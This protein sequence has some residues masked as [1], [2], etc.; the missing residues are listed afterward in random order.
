M[1]DSK[2]NPHKSPEFLKDW[3]I[4]DTLDFEGIT[5]DVT[6]WNDDGYTVTLNF[7]EPNETGEPPFSGFSLC[8]QIGGDDLQ[9]VYERVDILLASGMFDG[10]AVSTHGTIWNEDGDEIGEVN[11]NEYSDDDGEDTVV[12]EAAAEDDDKPVLH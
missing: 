1:S 3:P 8:T 11:W 10:I 6:K 2:D 12:E 4:L 9:E 7:H 5:V